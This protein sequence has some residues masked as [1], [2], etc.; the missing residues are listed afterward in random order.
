MTYRISTLI[1]CILCCNQTHGMQKKLVHT[2]LVT[3]Y[4]RSTKKTFQKHSVAFFSNNSNN[5]LKTDIKNIDDKI[6]TLEEDRS[7]TVYNENIE[8]IQHLEKTK[9]TK[10]KKLEQSNK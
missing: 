5:K 8:E 3:S 9:E 10:Q 1:I 2:I 7:R 6:K 4:N